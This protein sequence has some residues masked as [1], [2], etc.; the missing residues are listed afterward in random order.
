MRYSFLG[1]SSGEECL[2]ILKKLPLGSFFWRYD[3]GDERI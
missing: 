3:V 2:A 1:T